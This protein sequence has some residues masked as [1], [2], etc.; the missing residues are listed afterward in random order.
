MI[1]R[2]ADAA[3]YRAKE[4]GR[5]RYELF[6][7]D[8]RRRAVERI[9]LEAAIRQAVEQ[10]ELR[11]HYQ[12]HLVLHGLDEVTGVE[13][14]VRW[15]HPGR[16]LIDAREFMPLAGDI[17]LGVPIGR[18][19]LEHAL[20]QLARWRARK[21]DMTHLAQHLILRAARPGAALAPH[22]GHRRRGARPAARSASRSPKPT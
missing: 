12:P 2:E 13:A 4:R 9:E 10:C 7:E 5:S 6:D 20:A 14:L 17:G 16:G 19:V 22:A 11:V 1:I 18:F 15:D 21:P 3:M 8:S